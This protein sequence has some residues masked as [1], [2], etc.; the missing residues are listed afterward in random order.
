MGAEPANFETM[1]ASQSLNGSKANQNL[2]PDY[3]AFAQSCQSGLSVVYPL[4]SNVGSDP[5]GWKFAARWPPSYAAFGRMR[6]LLAVHDALSFQPR[7][8]L[9]VA[10]GGCGLAASLAQ[11]G[12]EVT[13]NDL[14]TNDL[15]E[16]IKEY[17]STENV[18]VVG[19]NLFDL[20]AKLGKFDLVVAC[21]IIEHV[22]HPGKLLEHLKTFLEPAG[23]I[24]LTT[25]NGSY[26]RNRLPTY[27]EITD[28]RELESRQF[29]PDADGHLF[30]FTPEELSDLATSVGLKIERLNV[31][32]TPLLSG[33]VGLRF[34]ANRFLARAAYQVELLTQHLPPSNREALCF[35]MSAVL[36]SE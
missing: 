32:G 24:L 20:S 36:R 22:A 19:G 28:F 29:M 25:P 9:E 33:H 30:L 35:A 16:A 4:K 23:R 6:S 15:S 2:F 31:W 3:A 17:E 10:A 34:L 5:Y 7:R 14:R 13:V 11:R 21:E 26:F 18:R 1:G 12:C 8:V 27:K